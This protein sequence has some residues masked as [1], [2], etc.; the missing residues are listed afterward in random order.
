MAKVASAV[1]RRDADGNT[2]FYGWEPMWGHNNMIDAAFSNGAQIISDDG[3][4]VL[5]DSPEWVEV[6]RAFANGYMKTTS[7]VFTTA[8]RAGSTGTRPLTM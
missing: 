6:W 8:A 7:C 1:T 4:T 2:S 3:K 5:I